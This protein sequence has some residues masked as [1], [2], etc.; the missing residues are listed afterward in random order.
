[1]IEINKRLNKI[2][3]EHITESALAAPFLMEHLSISKESAY[4][5]LRNEVVYTFKEAFILSSK[6]NISIDEI[7]RQL[8]EDKDVLSTVKAEK[9][10]SPEDSYVEMI[11]SSLRVIENITDEQY[12]KAYYVGNKIPN[13]IFSEFK[14]LSKLRYIRWIHQTHDLP[15]NSRFSDI[16]VP[17]AVERVHEDYYRIHR[18]IDQIVT[19]LDHNVLQAVINTLKFYYQRHLISDD[20]VLQMKE[21]LLGLIGRIESI[22]RTGRN[23]YNTGK[24]LYLSNLNIESNILLFEFENGM[25]A[26]LLSSGKKPIVSTNK[27]VCEDQKLWINSLLKFS[28]LIT[29]SNEIQQADFINEQYR[30]VESEIGQLIHQDG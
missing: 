28:V 9:E 29:C 26:H 14:M 24:L 30:L 15:I 4:R 23:L 8:N 17:P 13:G 20:E 11:K 10:I 7:F 1:M 21:E 27:R 19:I 5:R 12:V 3:A 2:L 6:L 18:K 25:S 22:S 16:I